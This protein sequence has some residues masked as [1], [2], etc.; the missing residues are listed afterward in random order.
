MDTEEKVTEGTVP[1]EPTPEEKVASLQ[2]E[3]EAKAREAEIATKRAQG[4]EGSLKEKD[5]LLR[6][7][8]SIDSRF[9][10][11]EDTLQILTYAVGKGGDIEAPDGETL[12]KHITSLKR[13]RE[14]KEKESKKMAEQAE[15]NAQANAV[16]AEAQTN[17]TD[18]KDLKMIELLLL[19]GDIA[20]A[21]ELIGS[22]KEEAKVETEA[23]MKERLEKEFL[24]KHNL[25]KP[26][27]AQAS[28]AGKRFYTRA[29][30]DNPDFYA[31]NRED[32]LEATR[33]GRVKD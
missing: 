6:D 27:T 32:I 7:Q 28:S 29:E 20:G 1:T 24:I 9:G 13:E 22:P 21:K 26:E 14:L 10:N 11:I 17:I 8:S 4:L 31:K 23:E 30:I 19:N 5:R 2:K 16:W 18:K 12:S 25:A 3:L 33:E 15:Y